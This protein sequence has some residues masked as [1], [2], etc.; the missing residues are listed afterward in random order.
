MRAHL[1][2]HIS[3]HVLNVEIYSSCGHCAAAII[4]RKQVRK[5]YIGQRGVC[6]PVCDYHKGSRYRS[7]C[8]EV[9]NPEG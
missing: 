6:F 3:D 1:I 7:L 4:H 2:V 5:C 9:Y 8:L